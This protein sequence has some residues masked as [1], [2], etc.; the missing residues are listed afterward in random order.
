MESSGSTGRRGEEGL[1]EIL[2]TPS[3]NLNV[4][5]ARSFVIGLSRWFALAPSCEWAL[6]YCRRQQLLLR[7]SLGEGINF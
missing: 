4:S 3:N 2:A 7:S 6:G 1:S 5:T